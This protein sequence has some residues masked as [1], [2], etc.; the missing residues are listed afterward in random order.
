MANGTAAASSSP[1]VAPGGVYVTND[2]YL[3][4]TAY[5]SAASTLIEIGGRVLDRDGRP[6]PFTGR[7]T[8]TTDRVASTVV[9]RLGEGRL[10]QVSVGIIG[11]T[12]SYGQTYVRVDLARGDGA[13]RTIVGT[14][15]AGLV[16]SSVRQAWPGSLIY[17]PLDRGGFIRSV[18]GTDPAAG[19]EISETVPTGARWRILSMR[20]S[21]VTDATVANRFVRVLLD[22]GTN[23]Y[24]SASSDRAVTLSSTRVHIVSPGGFTYSNAQ[25]HDWLGLPSDLWMLAGHRIRTSTVAIVAGDNYSAPVLLVEESIEGA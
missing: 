11:G 22:D 8:P 23:I 6:V 7:L 17:G 13:G 5:N 2:D 12:P 10:Q 4:L 16:T 9:V 1:I 21:L 19:V 15:I 18:V 25:D 24:G 20:F 3:L 14:L